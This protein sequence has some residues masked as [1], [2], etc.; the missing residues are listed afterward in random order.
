[1]SQHNF[2]VIKLEDGSV[3]DYV[4]AMSWGKAEQQ[5]SVD[6]DIP[7]TSIKAVWISDKEL[8]KLG[9]MP[10]PAENGATS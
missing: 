8:I 1:M 9:R 5:V 2:K 10:K 4:Q 3:V 6:H 7:R